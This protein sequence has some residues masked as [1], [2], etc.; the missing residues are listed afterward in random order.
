MSPFFPSHL[1]GVQMCVS[2]Y[3]SV[4]T[5]LLLASTVA[6]SLRT[7]TNLQLLV[8]PVWLNAKRLNVNYQHESTGGD[9]LMFIVF[10]QNK[11]TVNHKN[12]ELSPALILKG[13]RERS[14]WPVL[15]PNTG[16]QL[17]LSGFH[18]CLPWKNILS[19]KVPLTC[20]FPDFS[21]S[22]TCLVN[23]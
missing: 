18:Q 12:R 10:Y 17:N 23:Q 6:P 5:D 15:Q 8:K 2:R 7:N 21:S 19:P 1:Q 3:I 4:L 14:V 9:L 16:G 22:R 13:P 20:R 11:E